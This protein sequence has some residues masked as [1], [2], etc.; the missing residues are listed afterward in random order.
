MSF[1]Y[2]VGDF[3]LLVQLANKTFRNCQKAGEEY[4]EIS[5][6]VRCLHSVLKTLRAEA[7][8][9][10]SK[11]FKQDPASTAQLVATTEGCKNV[12]DNIDYILAKY[13][14]LRTDISA[15]A[16]KKLWQRFRFGSRTEELGVVRGKLITYT[17]TISIII[18][19]MQIRVTD[20]VESK[21]DGGFAEM[22]LQFE[23]MRKE[24]FD[25]AFNARAEERMSACMSSL[26]LS[27]YAGDE[28]VVWQ[29]FRRELL[30]KGFRSQSLER[31]KHVLQAYMLK[32]D[33]SGILDEA[34]I[35]DPSQ[36]KGTPWWAKRMYMETVNSLTDLQLTGH[37]PSPAG[38][39]SP[40]GN[41][42]DFENDNTE[43]S[44]RTTVSS[45]IQLSSTLK[46]QASQEAMG[47]LVETPSLGSSSSKYRVDID[48]SS[49]SS[50]KW[51]SDSISP[52]V[53]SAQSDSTEAMIGSPGKLKSSDASGIEL[54]A[55]VRRPSKNLVSEWLRREKIERQEVCF[56]PT[57]KICLSRIFISIDSPSRA[58]KEERQIATKRRQSISMID[59]MDIPTRFPL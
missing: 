47:N 3:I 24:I 34:L 48:V 28:K 38:N 41:V 14:G 26:S 30:K 22:S 53:G 19:T 23:K 40:E 36:P 18:D 50:L 2:S 51:D 1:G 49:I 57:L 15:G 39:M 17:S 10:D 5:C 25:I 46:R 33:Q 32:L 43:L 12:L 31:Y 56:V 6:E 52:I 55:K 44:R 21:I 8:R 54:N 20:R 4:A 58:A 27:T 13:E 29:D 59:P 16:G 45:G 9:D 7:Q 42:S 37:P 35:S 11:I